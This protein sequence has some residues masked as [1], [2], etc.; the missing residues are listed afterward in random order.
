MN[1]ADWAN[2]VA[3]I[4]TAIAGTVFC[5]SYGFT[6]PWWRSHLGRK[7]MTL[8]ATFTLLCMYVVV[9][10]WNDESVPNALRW[11]RA[12]L[13]AGAGVGFAGI[14]AVLWHDVLKYRKEV[15]E[16]NNGKSTER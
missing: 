8:A 5:L 1:M 3:S 4:W 14:T 6:A 2:Y 10:Y 13:V 7:L 11:L 15:K 12:I 9:F 16:G